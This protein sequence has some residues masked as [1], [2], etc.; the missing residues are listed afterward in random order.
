LLLTFLRVLGVLCG[1]CLFVSYAAPAS[2]YQK[3]TPMR[4]YL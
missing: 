4:L 1:E 2:R 3:E